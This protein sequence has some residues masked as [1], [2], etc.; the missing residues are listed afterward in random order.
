[1]YRTTINNARAR[2]FYHLAYGRKIDLGNYIYTFI[3][4]LG[5][6]IDKRHTDIFSAL[7]SGICK[8]AGVQLLLVESIL[9]SNG[10]INRYALKNAR[11]H[12]SRAMKAAPATDEQP[13][14]EH[15]AAPQPVAP[16]ADMASMLR[17][18]L[19]GQTQHTRLLVATRTE[20]KEMQQKVQ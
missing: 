18:I 16:P 17:Q 1:M 4:T 7:I 19:E 6:Q 11:R 10:L 15:A 20:L 9:K 5:F 2:L 3:S 13:Q 12:T 14:E 8:E